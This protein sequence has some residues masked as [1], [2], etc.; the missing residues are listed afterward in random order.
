MSWPPSG[1]R[2]A[3]IDTNVVVAALLTANFESPTVKVLDG[4]L[5]AKFP[6]AVSLP[7]LTEY[8]QVLLR[9]AISRRHGLTMDEADTLLIE[10]TQNARV[11]EQPERGPQAPEPG[12]QHL[13]DLLSAIPRPILVT[14]DRLLLESSPDFAELFDAR[15]FVARGD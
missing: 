14:G 11:I 2:T 5:A 13:W 1:H 15:G 8:R 4:M 9:P 6:F 7:L 12:D 10:I 3:V